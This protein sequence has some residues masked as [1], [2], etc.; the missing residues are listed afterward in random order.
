MNQSLDVSVDEFALLGDATVQTC[1][2]DDEVCLL[3]K[4]LELSK[5]HDDFAK[6]LR[7]SERCRSELKREVKLLRKAQADLTKEGEENQAKIKALNDELEQKCQR[8]A[9]KFSEIH[10]LEKRLVT[11]EADRTKL[12][13]ENDHYRRQINELNHIV[14]LKKSSSNKQ[15]EEIK[16]LQEVKKSLDEKL[17]NSN[18]ESMY[19]QKCV[20]ELETKLKS[21]ENNAEKIKAEKKDMEEYILKLNS[22]L[23]S[24]LNLSNV[25]HNEGNHSVD[26]DAERPG[27]RRSDVI[28]IIVDSD[29][30]DAEFIRSNLIDLLTNVESLTKEKENLLENL[31][32]VDSASDNLKEI[33]RNLKV[34]QE[35][36]ETKLAK[37]EKENRTLIE[38]LEESSSNKNK[39]EEA[40]NKA[41]AEKKTLVM[42]LEDMNILVNQAEKEKK[43]YLN[44]LNTFRTAKTVNEKDFNETKERLESKIRK[45]EDN[46]NTSDARIRS[47]LK[48]VNQLTEEKENLL[49]ELTKVN[50]KLIELQNCN[51]KLHSALNESFQLL[52]MA[53]EVQ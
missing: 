46:K 21:A 28:S 33:N 38:K 13:V 9:V 39:L 3:T 41:L 30:L 52:E 26:N 50:E 37:C 15:D 12:K 47:L 7:Q 10:D 8:E 36:L 14:E 45:L 34:K 48:S 27:S 22:V 24:C 31:A 6:I 25:S 4:W 51:Y 44:E 53:N 40:L 32:S 35:K 1:E 49:R 29:C 19:H 17:R 20:K 2:G 16:K 5:Q 42:R 23:R 11:A 18:N 43:R